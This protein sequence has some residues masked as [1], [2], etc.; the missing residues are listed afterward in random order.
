M[1]IQGILSLFASGKTTGVVLEIGDGV[2][3]TIPIFEGY[4]LLN[5]FGRQDFAGRDITEHL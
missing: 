2:A 5:A 3:Q 1:G 4:G